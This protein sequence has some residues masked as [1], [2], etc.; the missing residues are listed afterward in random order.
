MN[1]DSVLII[2]FENNSLAPV[3][4][5]P[6]FFEL[7]KAGTL[8]TNYHG[9][10]QPSQV[11]YWALS[12]GSI[13]LDVANPSTDDN[14]DLPKSSLF[15]LLDAKGV[16]WKVYCE[17]YPGHCFTEKGFPP[18]SF[19]KETTFPHENDD[20]DLYVRKHNP[21]ISYLSVQNN[22]E[23]CAKI[24][25]ASVMQKDLLLGQLPQFAFYI[26]TV[27]NDGHDTTSMWSG[28]YLMETW[29][30]LLRDRRFMENRIVVV[31]Y[32][33]N[34][35]QQNREG[36]TDCT[37]A[38]PEPVYCAFLGPSIEPGKVLAHHYDHY[39]LLRFVERHFELGTLHRCDLRRGIDIRPQRQGRLDRF[40]RAME[41]AIIT[42]A[43]RVL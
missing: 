29:S 12:G 43:G 39:D 42:A 9:I 21:A 23:R 17:S 18:A 32:D 20:H 10:T 26:P 33:E 25:N 3:L 19:P 27:V 22:P 14:V 7:A 6:Y 5:K 11:N 28:E 13:F 30:P 36:P 34:G 35:K 4:A 38:Q 1:K 37:Q 40:L 16:S 8:L 41:K 31:V 2:L 15:D 24:V